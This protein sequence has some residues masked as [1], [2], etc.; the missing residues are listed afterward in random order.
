MDSGSRPLRADLKPE[1][2]GGSPLLPRPA[3]TQGSHPIFPEPLI[4]CS[5][6]KTQILCRPWRHWLPKPS[7]TSSPRLSSP[8]PFFAVV[9]PWELGQ[10]GAKGYHPAT[11]DGRYSLVSMDS[12]ANFVLKTTETV[13]ETGR[14]ATHLATLKVT[15]GDTGGGGR[16]ASV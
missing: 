16:G 10:G 3:L 5:A 13:G 11:A 8:L 9:W 4:A 6:P 14:L 12:K 1:D 2:R 15:L 7:L